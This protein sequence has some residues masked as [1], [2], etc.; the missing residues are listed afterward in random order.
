M[1]STLSKHQ[2]PRTTIRPSSGWSALN[3]TEVWLY[4]DLLN[5]LAGRD[6]KLRYRQTALGVI[7]VI[8]QPLIAAGI[9]S[10]VF[11]KV[12]NLPS[13][14]I[15]YFLFAYAGLLGWNLFSSTLTK[16]SGCLTGNSHLISKVYFPRLVLPLST[17]HSSLIDFA[18]AAAMLVI[19]TLVSAVRITP[20][21]ALLPIWMV[22]I[23][24]MAVGL[25]LV[26]ASL[27]VSYR[28]VQFV[29]P[30][31]LQL[32]LYASPVAYAVSAVPGELQPF[33]FLNPLSSLLDAFRWSI[34]G[35]GQP[36]WGFVA[37][38][39]LASFALLTGGAFA[40]KRMERSFA[41]VI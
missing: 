6:V 31:M 5:S 17:L 23:L 15:P 29:I 4:R 30:V 14:G 9:F 28:D 11:G 32:G 10:F 36:Q 37:Y 21:L 39:L 1:D 24:M 38:G 16:V 2:K 3:L 13:D 7:W 22:A 20:A 25:G 12:A 19:L 41:D 35:V 26:G 18:V 33:Y 34:L 8:L 27:M 40:F